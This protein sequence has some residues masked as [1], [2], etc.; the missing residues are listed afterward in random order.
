MKAK[1]RGKKRTL[2]LH[3][4]TAVAFDDMMAHLDTATR[5]F[6]YSDSMGKGRIVQHILRAAFEAVVTFDANEHGGQNGGVSVWND[7]HTHCLF[8]WPLAFDAR[9]ESKDECQMRVMLQQLSEE[10]TGSSSDS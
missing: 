5:G 9:P 2:N 8:R 4:E 1:T 3:P 7:E 6:L 10:E